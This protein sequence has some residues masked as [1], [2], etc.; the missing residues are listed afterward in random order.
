MKKLI[1]LI[2]LCVLGVFIFSI[3]KIKTIENDNEKLIKEITDWTK[4]NDNITK[5]NTKY[6]AEINNLENELKDELKELEV[7][8][9]MEKRINEALSTG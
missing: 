5:E 2:F 9:R 1:I 8:E 6:E 4:N 7:W 3:V